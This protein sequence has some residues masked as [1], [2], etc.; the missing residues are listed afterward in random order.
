VTATS[1]LVARRMMFKGRLRFA[2]TA[3]GVGVAFFLAAAQS[4]LLIGWINTTTAIIR[5]TDAD[6]WVMAEKVP[7]FD[8]GTAI[9]R[10][11]IYQARSVPGVA[12]ADGL[13][14]A[15]N[16]WQR[17]DG[18]RMNAEVIGLGKGNMGGPWRMKEGDVGSVHLPETV[19]VDDLYMKALGVDRVGDSVGINGERAIVGGITQGIHTFTAAPFVFTSVEQAI[20]YDK[21]YQDDEITYVVIRCEP[22][23]DS[24]VVQAR[25]IGMLRNVEVLTT[26][27]FAVRSAKYWMLETGL[28]FTVVITGILGLAVGAV[29]IS[30]TLYAITQEHLP[31]YTTL[32]AL[33]FSKRTL[34]ALVLYQSL[35]FGGVGVALGSALFLPAAMFS[36]RTPIPLEIT[37]PAYGGLVALSLFSCASSSLLSIRNVF[38]TDP[39][40]VFQT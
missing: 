35:A 37:G 18:K 14:M 30:Q 3:S 22:G 36:A 15:W 5:H 9:P 32:L 4:G 16:Y 27:E 38:R 2:L 39:A 29:I 33:G 34:M 7:A 24:R 12:S 13:F 40:L 8:Y 21:R 20:R 6:L 10:Q 28:G 17:P 25:L 23:A 11:R 26:H 1:L 19:L 31:D